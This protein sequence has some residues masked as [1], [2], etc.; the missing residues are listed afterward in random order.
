MLIKF[1][2]ILQRIV[3]PQ[4]IKEAADE[5]G[6]QCVVIAIDAK[7]EKIKVDGMSTLKVEEKIQV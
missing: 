6:V 7:K 2:L 5:F 1:L 3:N 4:L